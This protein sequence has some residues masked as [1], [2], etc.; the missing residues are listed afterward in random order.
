MPQ[1]ILGLDIGYKTIKAVVLSKK[2]LSGGKIVAFNI[3]DIEAC[4]GLDSALQ[5]LA[6]EKIFSDVIC[7][8]VLPPADILF[9]RV[10]LPFRDENKIRKTLLFELEPLVPLPIEELI[11]D[12]LVI[13]DDGLLTAAAAKKNI[14]LWIDKL[15]KHFHRVPILDASSTTLAIQA[16]DKNVSGVMILDIG[17]TSTSAVFFEHGALMQAR[18]L[19]FG[20][21]TL[22]R[23]LAR[24]L[25]V[26]V[27]EAENIKRHFTDGQRIP[28]TLQACRLFGLELK[29]TIEFLKL[30][31]QIRQDP[32]TITFSGGGSLFAPLIQELAKTFSCPVTP[33]NLIQKKNLGIDDPIKASFEPLIMHTAIAAA[34]RFSTGV[35]SFNFRRDEFAAGQTKLDI[36]Q[37]LKKAAVI[38]GIII[39][40][41]VVHQLLD[42]HLKKQQL[43]TIKNQMAYIFKKDFPG[44]G[45]MVD[46][47]LQLKTKLEDDKKNFAFWEKFPEAMAADYLREVSAKIPPSLDMVVRQFSYEEGVLS[48]Q[49]EAKTMDDVSAIKNALA[50][51]ALFH[52]VVI[53]PTS[54]S[55]ESGRVDFSLRIKA[56]P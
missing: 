12:Y 3:L 30:N 25:S 5:K 42:Y 4:G 29:N 1:N 21:E 40:L 36:R 10:H 53:G 43:Q 26:S 45:P 35:V 19:P 34:L 27:S 39:G 50:Q 9:R 23:A 18:T 15:E 2:G 46:P 38:G 48:M 49:G 37:Q 20:G 33:L 8:A 32:V 31:G 47:V 22:T 17:S 16:V 24:D 7:V 55:R 11:A 54:F 13:P 14:R 6:E 51:S 41:A 56:K 28:E 52:E 44:A